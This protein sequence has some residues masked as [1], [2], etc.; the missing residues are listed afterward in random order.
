MTTRPSRK[1]RSVGGAA[2]FRLAMTAWS[3]WSCVVQLCGVG[4]E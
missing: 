1:R 3:L 4:R 2:S